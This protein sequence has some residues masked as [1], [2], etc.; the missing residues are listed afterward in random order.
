MVSSVACALPC[1]LRSANGSRTSEPRLAQGGSWW[2]LTDK[3]LTTFEL[4]SNLTLPCV[5][6]FVSLAN[7]RSKEPPSAFGVY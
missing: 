2:L 3:P 1:Y 5:V 6:L 7:D 4:G